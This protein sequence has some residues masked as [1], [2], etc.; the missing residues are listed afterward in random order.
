MGAEE[1]SLGINNLTAGKIIDTPRALEY[2]RLFGNPL[3]S[4]TRIYS[5]SLP[6]VESTFP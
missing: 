2:I 6:S 3:D 5:I 1:P 4:K